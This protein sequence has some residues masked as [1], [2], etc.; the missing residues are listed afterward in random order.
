MTVSFCHDDRQFKRS[1]MKAPKGRKS[2]AFQIETNH[3]P[4]FSPSMTLTEARK[5]AE[6]KARTL[7]PEG[8]NGR[9]LIEL[10][11]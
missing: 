3:G 10:L 1:H 2:W 9:V 6:Q 8:F 7:A 4:F 11:P 5:W